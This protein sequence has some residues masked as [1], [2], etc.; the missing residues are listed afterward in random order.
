MESPV[1][2]FSVLTALAEDGIV[3]FDDE[4][5]AELASKLTQTIIRRGT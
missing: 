5:V 1:G 2:Y 3:E 4:L